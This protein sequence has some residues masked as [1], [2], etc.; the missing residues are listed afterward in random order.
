MFYQFTSV[1]DLKR[2]L[3]ETL[4][5][6]QKLKTQLY[7]INRVLNL[8][9]EMC[10]EEDVSDVDYGIVTT[11]SFY[12]M[13]LDARFLTQVEL[14]YLKHKIRILPNYKDKLI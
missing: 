3:P 11:E 4:D 9:M 10:L 8:V 12:N 14:G 7:Q 6:I 5:R 1:N 13:L 2:R